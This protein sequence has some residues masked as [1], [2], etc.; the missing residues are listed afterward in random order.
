MGLLKRQQVDYS[1]TT[2]K[3]TTDLKN[4]YSNPPAPKP[5]TAAEKSDA[6]NAQNQQFLV[7][8]K[9]A[10]LKRILKKG[11]LPP[12]RHMKKKEKKWQDNIDKSRAHIANLGKEEE[13]LLFKYS[14]PAIKRKSDVCQKI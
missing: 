14:S 6:F 13:N 11:L 2:K 12:G 10:L 8:R 4:K 9:K 5:M 3:V 1:V 7:R